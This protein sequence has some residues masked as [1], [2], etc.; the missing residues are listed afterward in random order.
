M[1][2]QPLTYSNAQKQ[3]TGH[4][5]WDEHAQG[6][7][8]GVIVFPEAF[9]LGEHARERANRLAQAGYVALAADLQRLRAR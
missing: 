4:L 9:G 3:F 1:Q 7:R 8:P 6:V 5:A 2:T